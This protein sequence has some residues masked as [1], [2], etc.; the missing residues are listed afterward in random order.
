MVIPFDRTFSETERDPTLFPTIWKEELS[1]VLN[2]ALGGL[3]RLVQRRNRFEQPEKALYRRSSGCWC[4]P[5]LSRR[6]WRRAAYG[7]RLA[8]A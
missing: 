7:T 3:K 2:R 4:T 5:T 1:G 8:A 6:S